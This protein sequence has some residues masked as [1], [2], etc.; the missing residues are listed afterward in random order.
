MIFFDDDKRN[1]H[2]VAKLG[3]RTHH[4]KNNKGISFDNLQLLNI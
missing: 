4:I 1:I 3:V 2:S